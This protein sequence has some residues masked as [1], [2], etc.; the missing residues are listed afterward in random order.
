MRWDILYRVHCPPAWPRCQAQAQ[1]S[2]KNTA[3]TAPYKME[4]ETMDRDRS[5]NFNH[6]ITVYSLFVWIFTLWM[7]SSKD[8]IQICVFFYPEV[9]K[10]KMT[11]FLLYLSNMDYWIIYYLNFFCC[12]VRGG[13]GGMAPACPA[14][15]PLYCMHVQ[16]RRPTRI[17]A[18][19][20]AVFAP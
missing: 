20:A 5:K 10:K 19:A 15:P 4:P 17:Y 3:G 2:C 16:C 11:K 9:I 6:K 18:S 13:V 12:D 7:S 8:K 14:C 1:P